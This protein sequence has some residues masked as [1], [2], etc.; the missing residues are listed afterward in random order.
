MGSSNCVIHYFEDAFSA[1][2]TD[3]KGR[4]SAGAGFIRGLASSLADD[5]MYAIAQGPT[6][7]DFKDT[8]RRSGW[9]RQVRAL[10]SPLDPEAAAV[11]TVFC[12][13]P[14]LGPVSWMR[15]Q[16]DT[17]RFSIV[18]VTH[19]ICS[20]AVL[21]GIYESVMAPSRP[22]DAIICTS[23]AARA[24]IAGQLDRIGTF[25][26][27]R[28]GSIRMPEFELPVIPLGVMADDFAPPDAGARRA[29]LRAELGLSDDTVAALFVGRLAWH[30]KAHP[31]AMF[32]ALN[33]AAER[34]GRPVA[35]ILAGRFPGAEISEAFRSAAAAECPSIKLV[36]VDGTD[37]ARMADV[38][39]AG[40]FF[41]S[42]SDN[43][44]ETFGL[45]IIEAM[46]AGLPVVASDWDGY[47]DTVEDGVTGFRVPVLGCPDGAD[48]Q[49]AAWYFSGALSFDRYIGGVSQITAVDTA[50][51]T[52]CCVALVADAGLRARMGAAG[53]ARAR[54]L[55]DW[56]VVIRQY[57]ALWAELAARRAA[58]TEP[59]P[60]VLYRPPMET[61]ASFPTRRADGQLRV[62]LV[63]TYRTDLPRL[64]AYAMNNFIMAGLFD[65][66]RA[67][68]IV[69]ELER[70]GSATLDQLAAALP[71][72]DAHEIARFVLWMLKLGVL[73]EER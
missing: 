6:A 63:P 57:Q 22:W 58:A 60:P 49:L 10:R 32:Q 25:L 26:T 23:T 68:G 33:R 62:R 71:D 59:E 5:T 43:I 35:L 37:D 12:P 4:H 56:P 28:F 17:R 7:A 50:R 31:L 65:R 34:S 15:Q 51:A 52:E 42:L 66:R 14:N 72:M 16:A 48:A 67:A 30:A 41:I 73:V 70:A 39:H 54:R 61:F 9:T 24:A 18:G 8:V 38:W 3:L 44:Q 40:D 46:A 55:Y 1:N 45:T 29:R 53:R 69:A 19:T 64:S 21:Y 20:E 13:Y 27:A 36:Y 2:R 11:G 47:R